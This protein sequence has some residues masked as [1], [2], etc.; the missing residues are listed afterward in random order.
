MLPLDVGPP[1]A[2]AKTRVWETLSFLACESPRGLQHLE[3][4]WGQE[5]GS[6]PPRCL[7]HGDRAQSLLCPKEEL[8]LPGGQPRSRAAWQPCTRSRCRVL[9]GSLGSGQP[10]GLC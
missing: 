10:W 9:G 2:D 4:V 6:G 7:V 1:S 5:D 3:P 8:S